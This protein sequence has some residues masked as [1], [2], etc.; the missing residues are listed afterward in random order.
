[1]LQKPHPMTVLL[2]PFVL[3][4]LALF[5]WLSPFHMFLIMVVLQNRTNP[6]GDEHLKFTDCSTSVAALSECFSCLNITI[7]CAVISMDTSVLLLPYCC[8]LLS[9]LLCCLL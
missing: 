9:L 7:H 8:L 2:E 6:Y 1:M 4:S 3:M 5:D